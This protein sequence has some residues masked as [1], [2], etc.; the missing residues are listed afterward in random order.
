M[1]RSWSVVS[2]GRKVTL[3]HATRIQVPGHPE[4]LRHLRRGDN[5]RPVIGPR[6]MSPDR[7]ISAFVLQPRHLCRFVLG[8]SPRRSFKGRSCRFCVSRAALEE[9]VQIRQNYIQ[10]IIVYCVD[11]R[12][13]RR[14]QLQHCVVYVIVRFLYMNAVHNNLVWGNE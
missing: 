10:H 2:P 3:P 4:V 6:L 8:S 13:R 12:P 5:F 9:S 11:F 14:Y 7:L 1:R